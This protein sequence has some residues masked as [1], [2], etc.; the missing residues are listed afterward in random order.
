MKPSHL[1]AP[2]YFI[3][4]V[5]LWEFLRDP[6]GLPQFILP[7]PSEIVS[8]LQEQYGFLLG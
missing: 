2:L 7:T 5:V 3:G 6:L 8:A 4:G 1:Y